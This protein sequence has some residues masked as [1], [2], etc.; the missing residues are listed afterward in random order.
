MALLAIASLLSLSNPTAVA[1]QA[2]PRDAQRGTIYGAVVDS[3]G[4]PADDALVRLDEAGSHNPVETKT[5][6]AGT[7][8][9]LGLPSGSY[10]L[11]AEKSGLRTHSATAI[12][13]SAGDRKHIA[14][15]LGSSPDGQPSNSSPLSSTQPMGFSDSPNF[16]V[17]GVTDWTAVGGHGSD[18]ILRTSED[19]ARETLALKAQAGQNATPAKKDDASE[20]RLRTALAG[21]PG[22]FAANHQLGEFYL[23]AD[24]YRESLPLLAAAYQVDPA[25]D[26]NERDLTLAYE[27]IG[28]FQQAREHIQNLLKRKNNAD[29]HHIAGELDEKLG[30]PLAAVKEYQTAATLDPSEQNYFAWGSE[31]LLHRAVWQAV[32]VFRNGV[33]AYPNSAR[34]LTALGTALFAGALYDEAARRLCDASDLEPANPEPYIFMGKIEMASPRPLP[35]VE[36]KL[37]RFVREKPDSSVANYLYAMS[38]WKQQQ[39]SSNNPALQQVETLLIKAISLDA[40]CYD[41]YLQLGIL[42]A[43]QHNYEKAIPLYAKAIDIDPQLGEAHYRLGVAYDRLGERDKAQREFQLHDEIEKRQAAAVERE[44]RDVKQFVIVQGQAANS[45]TQ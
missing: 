9:F 10:T 26:A 6:A 41:G 30:D 12:P 14:L 3:A 8:Q 19:L 5:D 13:L 24:R 28:D 29:L 33:K 11:I 15:V 35:C 42:A 37:A 16:T 31:L 43:S 17:A 7:F 23:Q 25:N 34:L 2:S 36:A 22:S 45:V 32:E 20:S 18:S 40:K 39:S 38:I 44:R 1:Q 4:T 21:A 27:G